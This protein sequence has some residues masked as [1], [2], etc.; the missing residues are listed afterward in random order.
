[1]KPESAEAKC[2]RIEREEAEALW[3]K[4]ELEDDEAE[5]VKDSTTEETG[6]AIIPWD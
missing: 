5:C 4:M 3:A 6:S 2:D 1:M